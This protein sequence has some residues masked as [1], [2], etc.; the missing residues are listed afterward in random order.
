MEESTIINNIAD[1]MQFY[2]N[3]QN[4]STH[5]LATKVGCSMSTINR[6]KLGYK[7]TS[8]FTLMNISVVLGVTLNQL[9]E[10]KR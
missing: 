10:N 9:V 4:L 6:I 8:L 3:Q 5:K 2:M 1:N 7:S